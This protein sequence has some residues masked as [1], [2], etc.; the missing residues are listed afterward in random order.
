MNVWRAACAVAVVLTCASGVDAATA[1]WN[2]NPETNIAGYWLSYGTQSGLH[3]TTIDVG[4][5]V[6]YQF[7]P[8]PGQRYYVVVQAYNTGGGVGPKSNEVI[9]D[10]PAQ[11]NQP[12]SLTQPA[13]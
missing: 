13:T 9:V 2:R 12:P 8:P 11:Q 6:S 4:N 1:T 10:I 3:T 5:V 7:F